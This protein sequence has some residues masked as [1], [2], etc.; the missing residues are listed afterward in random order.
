MTGSI[1][2][3]IPHCIRLLSISLTY[4]RKVFIGL[5]LFAL[6]PLLVFCQRPLAGKITKKASNE[7]IAGASI[8]NQTKHVYNVSDMGGNYRIAATE[9]DTLIFSSAGYLPDTIIIQTIDLVSGLY[10]SLTPFFVALPSVTVSENAY[11]ADSIKRREE[12]SFILDKKHPVKLVN[13]KR[14]GDAPGLNFSPIG[15]FSTREK[16]KRRLKKRLIQQEEDYYIDYKFSAERVSQLSGLKGD[17]LKT[18]VKL[19]RPSYEFCRKTDNQLMLVYINDKLKLF[20]K[21]KHGK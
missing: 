19:Y 17:S 2:S 20:M 3:P 4:N 1:I 7:I 5:A 9:G 18:F 16:Q 10:V 12:Y 14:V 13:E 11:Q 8:S 15:Y 21:R 6:L